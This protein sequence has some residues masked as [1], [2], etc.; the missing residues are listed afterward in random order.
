MKRLALSVL[1]AALLV[2][3]YAVANP[4]SLVQPQKL[5]P[6]PPSLRAAWKMVEGHYGTLRDDP[7]GPVFAVSLKDQG[8]TVLVE[9]VGTDC[10]V[11]GGDNGAPGWHTIFPLERIELQVF[12]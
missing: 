4:L 5:M 11:L 2:T 1:A 12:Q 9:S 10:V 8:G 3:G 6:A 7:R